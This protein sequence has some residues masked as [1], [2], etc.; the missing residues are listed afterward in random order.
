MNENDAKGLY[1]HFKG[2]LYEVLD[3]GTHTET[4]ERLVIYKSIEG[5]TGIW[6]RPYDMF[7]ETVLVNKAE[8]SRFTKVN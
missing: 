5:P 8:V 7:F 2:S 3:V 6:V 4:G 1:R